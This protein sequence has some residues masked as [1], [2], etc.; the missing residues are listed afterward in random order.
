MI[1]NY[2]II[3]ANNLITSSNEIPELFMGDFNEAI[4]DISIA[5]CRRWLLR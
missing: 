1:K 4:S 3:P 2:T 5:C